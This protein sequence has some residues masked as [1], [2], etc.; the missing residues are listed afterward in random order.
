MPPGQEPL[1]N[2]IEMSL[3]QVRPGGQS[4]KGDGSQNLRLVDKTAELRSTDSRGGCPEH[5]P[6]TGLGSGDARSPACW[7]GGL[8]SFHAH[9]VTYIGA[10]HPEDHILGNIGGVVG[11]A[12]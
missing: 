7:V 4:R 3:M 5:E 10:L 6:V 11:N 8:R 1:Q 2:E 12:F 9:V